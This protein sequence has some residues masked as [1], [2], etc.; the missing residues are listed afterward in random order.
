[1]RLWFRDP[2]QAERATLTRRNERYLPELPLP[3]SIEMTADLAGAVRGV[4]LIVVAVPTGAV[5]QTLAALL[6]HLP[7]APPLLLAAKG[8][9]RDTGRRLTEVAA[10][11]LGDRAASV[12]VLSGPNLAGEIV[13]GM[14][15]ATVIAGEDEA[16]LREMQH[17]FGTPLFR[18]YTN[19]DV[20]GV[21]LG[22]A[23]K[24]PIALAAGI[25]DGL[26]FGNNTKASLLTRGLAEITRLG[27][28]AGAR[29]STFSGLSGVGDLL[30]TA[31]SPL[32]RNYRVGFALGQGDSLPHAQAALHQVAEGVPTTEAACR[33][34]DRLGIE[35]PIMQEL[36]K[37]LFEGAPVRECVTRLM[38]RP[39]RGE[40][41][42]E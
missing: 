24:N 3:G 42:H 6:P 26:G 23:L 5:R 1:V 21:E 41:D 18:V 25:S 31:Y 7:G 11:V 2:E 9:E 33:L 15:A 30:T 37:L 14:P 27:V 16:T 13:G 38:T 4:S 29:A 40:A 19:P 17:A 34:A 39:Y 32:S 12:A 22:G 8:L 35:A 20:A 28:A 10:E 36:R